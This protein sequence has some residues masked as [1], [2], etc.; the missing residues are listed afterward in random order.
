MKYKFFCF[1][2]VIILCGCQGLPTSELRSRTPIVELT[3]NK[4]VEHV[5]KCVLLNKDIEELRRAGE[6]M[7]TQL[8]NS[9]ETEILFA[10]LQV[11]ELKGFYQITLLGSDVNITKV[12]MR[13]ADNEYPWFTFQELTS[14][15]KECSN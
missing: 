6:A 10:R 7:I 5:T 14:I 1:S 15:V 9:N 4:P 13:K 8:P 3:I 2:I 12:L 11:G